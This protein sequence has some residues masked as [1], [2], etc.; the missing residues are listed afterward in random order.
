MLTKFK[1]IQTALTPSKRIVPA[2]EQ[3]AR[4]TADQADRPIRKLAQALAS[5]MR[6]H[7]KD[8]KSIIENAPQVADLPV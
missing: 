7:R 8:K 2:L 3:Q 1:Y 6:N 5:I 4:H